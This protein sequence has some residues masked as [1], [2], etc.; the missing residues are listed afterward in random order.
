M[1][2]AAELISICANMRIDINQ[3]IDVIPLLLS[4]LFSLVTIWIL[5]PWNDG[6]Y[7]VSIIH[8]LS[9]GPARAAVCVWVCGERLIIYLS[10]H[11]DENEGKAYNFTSAGSRLILRSLSD[12]LF[13]FRCVC[14][15]ILWLSRLDFF[16]VYLHRQAGILFF[17][18]LVWKEMRMLVFA[19]RSSLSLR[20]QKGR[21]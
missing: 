16:L 3:T 17:S 9:P 8:S 19:L 4:C 21:L 18:F 14:Q 11:A 7:T 6:G 15:R 20:M 12:F 5:H 10:D 1:G 13:A 2:A